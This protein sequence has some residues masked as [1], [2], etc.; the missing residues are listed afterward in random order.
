MSAALMR[1]MRFD[2]ADLEAN[3]LGALSPA[4]AARL[5]QTRR[6]QTAIAALAFVALVILATSLIY[7]GQRSHNQILILSGWLLI[8]LNAILVL[9]LGRAYMRL[10]SDMRAGSIESLTGPV[11]RVLRRGRQ[12]DSYLIRIADDSLP[13]SREVFLSFRHEASYRI[14]RT[15]YGR[16]LLSAEALDASN[17][18]P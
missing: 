3:R 12:G 16:L 2:D 9:S 7:A 15:A 6:R 8:A 5:R 11:E 1:A 10:G 17:A 18:R 4:Q 13:V 14:Y